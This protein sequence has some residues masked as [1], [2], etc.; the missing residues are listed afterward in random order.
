MPFDFGGSDMF[1]DTVSASEGLRS[2]LMTTFGWSA[3]TAYRHMGISSMN[4]MTDAGETVSQ[5]TF[6]RIRDWAAGHH[7]ARLSF[8]AVNR[9]HPCP[10]GV[11]A[12]DTCSGIAQNDWDFT[13][14]NAG[15]AG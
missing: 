3:D 7:L 1:N 12:G 10:S 8:W 15:Y 6:S 2:Q 13:R 11:S 4:G 9:D 5:S 14:I